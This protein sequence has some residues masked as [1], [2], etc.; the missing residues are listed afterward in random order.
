MFRSCVFLKSYLLSFLIF[1]LFGYFESGHAQS[2][3]LEWVE[4][5]LTTM[6]VNWIDESGE[7][8]FIEYRKFGAGDWASQSG[9]SEP[10]PG[11]AERIY[12]VKL[13]GLESGQAYEFRIGGSGSVYKFRTAPENLEE[14][15]RFIVAGDFLDSGGDLEEA[16]QDFRD[17]SKHAASYDPYFVAVGGDLA[18]AEGNPDNVEQWFFLFETWEQEMITEDG[19]MIPMLAA[20]GNNDVQGNFGQDPEAAP[21]F[22]TFFS[23]PQDQWGS[24]ISYGRIDFNKYLSIVTLDSDHTHR[25]PGDQTNWLD[26][27]LK[28]RKDFRHIIPYYHVAGWPSIIG[29]T[30]VGTQENLV[31][32]NWHKVFRENNIR[33]VFEH[34]DHVYKRTVTLGD[35]EDEI[36][37]LFDCEFGE[38]AKDGVIYMGGG[39]WGSDNKRNSEKRWYHQEVIEEIHNFVVVEIDDQKRKATAVGENGQILDEFTDY[40]NLPPPIALNASNIDESGFRAEWDAVEGATQ[41]RLDV[42]TDPDFSSYLFGFNN[43]NVGN[44]TDWDLDDLDPSEVYYYRV[45]AENELTKSSV[46]NV[47]SVKLVI[48]DPALSEITSTKNK[49]IADGEDTAEISVKVIDEDNEPV[50][51]F[52]VELFTKQG[53][54]GTASATTRTDRDGIARF[55]VYNDQPEVVVYGARA[56]DIE[57]SGEVQITF[58]P[59]SPV[60]LAANPVGTR[61]FQANWEV[62][63]MADSYQIDVATDDEFMNILPQYEALNTGNVTSWS[64]SGINPGQTYHYRVR[65]ISGELVGVNSQSISTIT[66]PEIPVATNATN[67]NSV[68]FRANW[69]STVGAE[70]YRLDVATDSEFNQYVEGYQGLDVGDEL[71]VLVENLQPGRTYFYRLRAV[72][73]PR[74]SD[75]SNRVQATTEPLSSELS[76]I[77]PE[78]LKVLANGDQ[79]NTIAVTVRGESGEVQQGVSVE[80]IPE[81]GSSKIDISQKV[82][83]EGGIAIFTVT[84]TVAEEVTYRVRAAGENIG[85]FTV[86]FLKDEGILVLGKNFPNPFRLDSSIPVTIP[87]QMDV[88]LIVYNSLGTPVKTILDE[89]LEQGYYEVPFNGSDLASGVYFYRLQADGHSKVGKMLLIK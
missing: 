35:C 59:I 81:N 42:S 44:T 30:L 9:D 53:Q 56:G 18:N 80:L 50:S 16:K 47:I 13:T 5:P 58:I 27:T 73:G 46:S 78:Q 33:L 36:S 32:N 19:F 75:Y 20:L 7:S 67:V 31:R 40:V 54:L 3:Y 57:I 15:I 65:A 68:R 38:N 37:N 87:S 41:Y 48:V 76:D 79:T 21:L 88:E 12:T 4:D 22:Y 85:S 49:L 74:L 66:F 70:A 72:A 89:T 61:E 39:S 77:Q 1:L 24:K 23:Y 64:V 26:N 2:I 69:N 34:H 45:S 6:V 84:N 83:N 52:E 82:T 29:R 62:V 71:S 25:I 51:N 63:G 8:E 43:R 28:N 17:V 86:E 11:A 60:A 55:E 14:P 10:I